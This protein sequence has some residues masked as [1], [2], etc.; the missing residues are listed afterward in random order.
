M[1]NFE[2]KT[3]KAILTQIA[4]L[5]EKAN[6]AFDLKMLDSYDLY[7]TKKAE[8]YNLASV[9]FNIPNTANLYVDVKNELK[10]IAGV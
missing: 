5:E 6:K 4:Q 10:Q 7:L 9:L 3:A 8:V 1:E 2:V